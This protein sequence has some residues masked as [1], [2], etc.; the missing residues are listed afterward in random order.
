MSNWR[1]KLYKNFK[2]KKPKEVS[3]PFEFEHL[4]HIDER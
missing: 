4:T 2:P 1:E 3:A